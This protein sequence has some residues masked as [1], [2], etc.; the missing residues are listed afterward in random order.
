[1][2]HQTTGDESV[3]VKFR[4]QDSVRRLHF[5]RLPDIQELVAQL[6]AVT[7][8]SADQITYVDSDGDRV[9]IDTTIELRE[10]R[11]ELGQKLVLDVTFAPAPAKR[12]TMQLTE[13]DLRAAIAGVLS[14]T[15]MAD[16]QNQVLHA[17][18]SRVQQSPESSDVSATPAAALANQASDMAAVSANDAPNDLPASDNDNEPS[19]DGNSN[20]DD[21]EHINLADAD[22]DSPAL[23]EALVD[24]VPADAV[25]AEAGSVQTTTVAEDDKI[26]TDTMA[27]DSNP[28]T[29]PVT[30]PMT[31]STEPAAPTEPEMVAAVEPDAAEPDATAS[32]TAETDATADGSETSSRSQ[33]AGQFVADVNMEDGSTLIVGQEY[34][35]RWRVR[36]SGN[37]AW[38]PTLVLCR[39]IEGDFIPAPKVPACAP[40]EEVNIILPLHPSKPGRIWAKFAFVVASDQAPMGLQFWVDLTVEPCKLAAEVIKD[41]PMQPERTGPNSVVTKF[42]RLRNSGNTRWPEGT[43]LFNGELQ[44]SGCTRVVPLAAPGE[45]VMASLTLPTPKIKGNFRSTWSLSLPDGTLLLKNLVVLVKI[46]LDAPVQVAPPTA[47]SQTV[48]ETSS[49]S[50]TAAA[51]VAAGPVAA[52]AEPYH[53]PSMESS[54]VAGAVGTG[55]PMLLQRDQVDEFENVAD[56]DD[57]ISLVDTSCDPVEGMGE[58][59]LDED[60]HHLSVHE[61]RPYNDDDL[62][63]IA[64]DFTMATTAVGDARDLSEVNLMLQADSG[65]QQANTQPQHADTPLANAPT[66]A[67]DESGDEPLAASI[68]PSAPTSAEPGALPETESA[69]E[70]PRPAACYV[71][72][73]APAAYGQKPQGPYADAPA[74]P[75]TGATPY[76]PYAAAVTASSNATN[77]SASAPVQQPYFHTLS[78]GATAAPVQQPYYSPSATGYSGPVP[79]MT[80]PTAS[81]MESD[82]AMA[83]ALQFQEEEDARTEAKRRAEVARR[84]AAQAPPAPA[85]A[86]AP[87]PAPMAQTTPDF[88]TSEQEDKLNR[89]INMGFFNRKRS[90]D[91][92]TRAEFN[93]EQAIDLLVSEDEHDGSWAGRR[94]F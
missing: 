23:A 38:D 84:A 79:P 18:W 16:L 69:E 61:M 70:S 34:V 94:N 6:E 46:R 44:Q 89:L 53:V 24:A 76:A 62:I 7:K 65:E 50:T 56:A 64:S 68:E 91:A 30:A 58:S 49:Q 83:R 32:A 81:H 59:M 93:I 15:F 9:T 73:S 82:A 25:I 4:W 85:P 67:M 11:R 1:M 40:G 27:N 66:K 41:L 35:K 47:A 37:V 19:D 43:T 17:V 80:T 48:T 28:S 22:M 52:A 33:L 54:L 72:P 5:E 12:S 42:W 86:P 2:A 90:L 10:A 77:A 57:I 87:V 29:A 75:I 71:A 55:T 92:L 39:H 45:E 26:T 20:S 88:L 63:S 51:A 78:S 60:M 8:A 31:A 3:V 14:P 21:F 13:D 36:N 74:Y